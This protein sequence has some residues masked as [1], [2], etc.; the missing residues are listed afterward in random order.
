[1]PYILD[2][3][4]GKID[5]E[6]GK[7]SLEKFLVENG[8]II[9]HLAK[10]VRDKALTIYLV[11]FHLSWFE[12][13]VGEIAIRQADLAA[14][15]RSGKGDFIKHCSTV[16]RRMIDLLRHDCVKIQRSPGITSAM[17]VYLPTE[18][19]ACRELIESEKKPKP[20]AAEKPKDYYRDRAGRL[21]ILE[22]DHRRCIYCLAEL[23]EKSY[24]IDHLVPLSKGGTDFKNNL[25]TSCNPCNSKKRDMDVLTFLQQNY[26]KGLLEQNEYLEQRTIIEKYLKQGH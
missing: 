16:R 14:H 5:P 10:V 17:T 7:I 19:R 2:L 18:I 6:P 26:R 25:A 23:D 11:L 21:E 9:S 8:Y 13:G 4:N 1:M 22:R 12:T 24:R 20:L 15:I 3:A